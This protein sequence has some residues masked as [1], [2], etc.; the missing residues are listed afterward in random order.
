MNLRNLLRCMSV[1]ALNRR[2]T[3]EQLGN[4]PII[5]TDNG[6]DAENWVTYKTVWAAAVNLSGSEYYAAAAVKAEKT[7]EFVIRYLPGVTTKM[8]ISFQDKPYSI[9][10]VDN[11][12][13]ANQFMILRATEVE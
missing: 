13:Y 2:I 6:F 12:N 9:S 1:S 7:T 8:R 4:P 3:I 5:A 11:Y 10:S